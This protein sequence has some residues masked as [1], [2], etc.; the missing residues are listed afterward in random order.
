MNEERKTG[1]IVWFSSLK[2]YGFC[3]PDDGSKDLFVHYSNIVSDARFKT[4]VAGQVVSFVVGANKNGPQA[5]EI[6]VLENPPEL[7]E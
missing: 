3:K 1:T 4:L 2:G 7:M 6:V 5:E